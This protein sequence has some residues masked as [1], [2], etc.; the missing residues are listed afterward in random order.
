MKTTLFDSVFPDSRL[1]ILFLNLVNVAI[2][3]FYQLTKR[4]EKKLSSFL[5]HSLFHYRTPMTERHFSFLMGLCSF[6][7]ILAVGFK[8]RVSSSTP[9]EMLTLFDG[10]ER[11]VIFIGHGRSGHSLIGSLLDAH[12]EIIVPHEC[13]LIARWKKLGPL[14]NKVKKYKLFYELYSTSQSQAMFGLRSP[15]EGSETYTYHVPGTW[16][17]TYRNHI[18]VTGFVT[19]YILSPNGPFIFHEM[20]CDVIWG[21]GGGGEVKKNKL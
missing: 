21:G 1:L 3:A 7:F 10:V 20:G 6:F 11:I 4:S 5:T 19:I 9:K 16:Q 14:P 13:D 15:V 18:K 12:P 8:K 17:G 2:S